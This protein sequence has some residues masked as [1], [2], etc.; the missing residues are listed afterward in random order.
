MC[1]HCLGLNQLSLPAN[2]YSFE[3]YQTDPE[4]PPKSTSS[5]IITIDIGGNDNND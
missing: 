4:E 5:T 2:D 3:S 1:P